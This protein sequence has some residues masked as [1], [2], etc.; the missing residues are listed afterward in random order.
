MTADVSTG[1]F[2]E[3][4]AR[5]RLLDADHLARV[6]A[7]NST[8]TARE[9]A[10]ALV[11]AG[12]LTHF[13]ASKLLRGR[14][15][16]L[17]IGPYRLLAPLGRGGMGTVYLARDVR[18]A[19]ELGDEVL[20]ALKVLPPRVARSDA[21]MRERFRRE[22]ELGMRVNDPNVARTLTGGEAD[23]VH[24]LAMEY[25]PG[26]TIRELVV[27]AG[28][29][30][31]G[32]AARI[33]AAVAA[34]LSHIHERG[35]IHRDLKPA[36]VMLTPDGRAKLL[37]LGLALAPSDPLPDDRTIVGGKGYILGTMDYI[38]PE[39][40][41]DAT[42][43]TPRSDLY[44][45]GCSLYFALTGSPPFPGGTSR[46][47][48]R[49]QLTEVP[50]PL[51]GMNPTVPAEFARIVMWLMA[52]NPGDRPASATAARDALLPFAAA[53]TRTSHLSVRDAVGAVDTPD[54]NPE[55][56]IE[57]EADEVDRADRVGEAEDEEAGE[58]QREPWVMIAAVGLGAVVL[59]VLLGLLRRL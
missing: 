48:I 21:R 41:R 42:D 49:R 23:G 30:A 45:M 13:Q 31:V 15:S 7:R 6:V 36:N 54:A 32:D 43:V 33:F 59:L 2:L 39:Q 27:E 25:V 28:P 1:A 10:D 16:G 11:R 14:H 38:A 50:A 22:I 37:D 9:L 52:K 40:G 53:P 8:A 26:K 47:K 5:S 3:L 18:M 35:L 58:P 4:A 51:S 44:A 24:F 46:E 17:A 12:D 19:E 57:D 34:G 55:L 56:W 29:F 20:V